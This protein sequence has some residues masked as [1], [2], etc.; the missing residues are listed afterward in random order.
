MYAFLIVGGGSPRSQ[1]EPRDESGP[2]IERMDW[3]MES[4]SWAYPWPLIRSA[5]RFQ[6]NQ[7]VVVFL[8]VIINRVHSK[9]RVD[10]CSMPKSTFL[11][12]LIP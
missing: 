3:P 2:L 6:S 7:G 1:S 10:T 4:I 5:A 9:R 12:S 11:D 8:A